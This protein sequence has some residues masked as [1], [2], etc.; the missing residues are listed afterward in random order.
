VQKA[1]HLGENSLR[2][3]KKMLEMRSKRRL[4]FSPEKWCFFVSGV[5]D[6]NLFFIRAFNDI[7][8]ITPVVWK[9]HQDNYPVCVYCINPAYDIHNDYRLNFLRNLGIPV[10]YVY[11][12]FDRQLGL[13]HRILMYFVLW[14]FA[15]ERKM[16]S[17]DR[18]H[19][20]K[21][22]RMIAKQAGKIGAWFYKL[23]KTKYY[24]QRC[25]LKFLKQIGARI[26]CFDWIRPHKYVVG[27]ILSA[28]KKIS[29]P[30]VALPHGV[31]LYTNEH[32]Q[33]ES[34]QNGL[35][36]RYH[37]Y[38]NVIVQNNSF[39]NLISKSGVDEKK[40][41]VLGSARY[42]DEWMVQNNKIL[43]R[44]IKPQDDGSKKLKVVFMTTRP[45]YRIDV[46]RMIQTFDILSSLDDIEVTIKPHTRTGKEAGLYENIP[47][48]NVSEISSIE[49]CEW[50]D[51][52]L[53]IGSS[54]IIEAL[55][56]N[57]PALYLKYLHGNITEYEELK[58]CWIIHDENELRMALNALKAEKKHR[59]YADEDVDRFLTEII[60]GGQKDRDVLTDYQQFIANR[61]R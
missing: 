58:A 43:P 23:A 32:V 25:A 30:T 38:D 14:S 45:H 55:T 53:V 56:R 12:A 22:T 59:P 44:Q 54:I 5:F 34:K 17:S 51:V 8:H 40:I 6:M 61:A 39:K 2:A 13:R 35:L 7:D 47:L 57:K 28:A 50:A 24:D 46:A 31:F 19:S 10:D 3:A 15:I 52:L 27:P 42:C 29:I 21:A 20:L 1:K 49:L 48:S 33:T 18:L 16:D 36:E 41:H 4:H 37:S 11:R 9:M 26:L 60:Y